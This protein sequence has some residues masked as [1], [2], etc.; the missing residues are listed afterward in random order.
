MDADDRS[1][2]STPVP[3]EETPPSFLV[4]PRDFNFSLGSGFEIQ[5]S[6]AGDPSPAMSWYHN[7]VKIVE[8]I[9]IIDAKNLRRFQ[10]RS[11]SMPNEIISR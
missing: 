4:S 10:I 9:K 3:M 7:G 6:V 11:D 5:C 2:V 8:G 1:E